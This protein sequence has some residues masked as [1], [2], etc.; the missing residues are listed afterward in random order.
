[1]QR[2][3]HANGVVTYTFDTLA[4]LPVAA[5]VS[6]RHGGVSP[7]PWT[8]L[9]FSVAR[10]DDADRVA[11]N[12]RR[13]GEALDM[14]PNLWVTC[15][16][17]HGTGVARVD[18]SQAGLRMAGCDALITDT[19]NLP[20]VLVFG[21]CTP[22]LLYDPHHHALG[23]CHAGWRGTVNGAAAAVVWAMQAA[24]NSEPATLQAAIGPSIGPDS[25]EVGDEVLQMA[26]AKLPGAERF[27]VWPQ[28]AGGKP[29]FDLWQANAV[30]LH[31]AGLRLEHIEI[32]GIDTARSTA[33]FFSHRAEQ[34][35]CGLFAMTAMLLPP[36]P[37]PAKAP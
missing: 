1:M 11:E 13:L 25:Y 5:H 15:T 4:A 35:R 19:L 7:A 9:N 10:G 30:Q 23:I 37:T 21:D 20:L 24:F 18:D 29:H 12:R 16:Q 31:E 17:V 36:S 34:G 2:I 14:P 32:A 27:F 33:E 26:L 8:G 3:E 22:I 6:T 28:G